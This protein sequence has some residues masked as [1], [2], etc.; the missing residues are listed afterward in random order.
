MTEASATQANES[1]SIK[2]MFAVSAL[3]INL[4]HSLAQYLNSKVNITVL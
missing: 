3:N 1:I 2:F 4:D